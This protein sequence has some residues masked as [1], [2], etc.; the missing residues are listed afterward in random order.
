[1]SQKTESEGTPQKETDYLVYRGGGFPKFLRLLWTVFFIFLFYYLFASSNFV[2]SLSF[3][4]DLN[5]WIS[6]LKK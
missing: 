3:M 4:Q 1:M 5:E 6:K 2:D